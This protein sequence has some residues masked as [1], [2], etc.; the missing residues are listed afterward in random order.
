[1]LCFR[2]G[3]PVSDAADTCD[4]C[5]Q[6]LSSSAAPDTERFAEIQ[7]K[8]RETGRGWKKPA[9]SYDVGEVIAERYEINDVVGAGPLGTV[10]KAFDQEVEVDVA[11]KVI[12]SEYLP[13]E[14]ARN[15][16]LLVLQS[17]RDLVHENVVRCF[18]VDHE[19]DR[20]FYVMQFLKGLTLRKIIDMRRAK[21][22]RFSLDEVEPIF[23]QLCK[24]LDDTSAIM[25]HGGLKPE[26]I[27]ILPDLLKITD[28]G[29]P[30]ALP[31]A[32]YLTAQ[33]GY[34]EASHYL[35]PEVREKQDYDVRAD[36]YSAGVIL[37]ELL[38]G[39]PYRQGDEVSVHACTEEVPEAV[40]QLLGRTVS[41]DPAERPS[42]TAQLRQEL[43]V[44]L[45][46]PSEG[47]IRDAL[48]P[49][50]T[51]DLRRAADPDA[52][53]DAEADAEAEAEAVTR[54]LSTD[55]VATQELPA[56]AA[57]ADA[58]V[59]REVPSPGADG[60]DSVVTTELPS[61]D[62]VVTKEHLAPAPP[63]DE[64][65]QTARRNRADLETAP[66]GEPEE[67]LDFSDPAVPPPEKPGSQVTHQLDIDDVE[68]A[69]QS[70]KSEILADSLEDP[71]EDI[72]TTPPVES[73]ARV[74]PIRMDQ[75]IQE[76]EDELRLS[77]PDGPPPERTQQIDPDM[78]MEG[79]DGEEEEEDREQVLLVPPGDINHS[80]I[81]G[82]TDD[83]MPP[84][85]EE[86]AE[87]S[88]K[89]LAAKLSE[90]VL[91]QDSIDKEV[92]AREALQAFDF[93]A[94]LQQAVEQAHQEVE[95]GSGSV[96]LPRGE[97]E[98]DRPNVVT[99]DVA[100][101]ARG[102]LEVDV[103]AP[104]P[105]ELEEENATLIVAQD[106]EDRAPMTRFVPIL[107]V[108]FVAVLALGTAGAI[109]FITKKRS[110]AALE[111][112]ERKRVA[113][114]ALVNKKEAGAVEAKPD[115]GP[116][117]AALPLSEDASSHKPTQP[118]PTP[119]PE[120]KPKVEPKP[121][122]APKPAPKP[123][124]TPRPR[125]AATPVRPA[126]PTP[127]RVAPVRPSPVKPA[128]AASSKCPR[129]M[130]FISGRPGEDGHCIDLFEFPGRGR[131]P[132]RTGLAGAK[133][134]CRAR[135]LRLCTAREWLRGCG[136]LFPYGRK[137][138][139]NRC[140]TGTGRLVAS[141]GKRRCRSRWGLY[142]MSGNASEWVAD[143]VTMG[144]DA[145]SKEG[146][147]GCMARTR[148]GPLT[149]FRCCSDPSWD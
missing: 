48:G 115:T 4:N 49:P 139:P 126:P 38:T 125:R 64:E 72:L 134:A 97:P 25:P 45:G 23:V 99:P 28:F 85:V 146:H 59:T 141:G 24:A 138:D 87:P 21:G 46:R 9:A 34:K 47:A 93:D 140:N 51:R 66:P 116:A 111:E 78:I 114:M 81:A 22:Q 40:D 13:D 112:L 67:P 32:A 76:T 137:Y 109:Y 19:G 129:G 91:S 143:G 50:I 17:A 147:A 132:K 135:G 1:M 54:Q 58:M 62:A 133:A 127:R 131:V 6:N 39:K 118:E 103:P 105:A 79:E 74:D 101:S 2:C 57:D 53:A 144:G 102:T 123:A 70:G 96:P 61:P 7:K 75:R 113:A 5:G 84:P 106:A 128:P 11:L 142:D 14:E 65:E 41:V 42:T 122:P 145:N 30:E 73:T 71:E 44:A 92:R 80:Q 100:L 110:A 29:L 10:Y 15:H 55:A 104:T 108:A 27:V 77:R 36:V 18:D 83:G 149:G 98:D 26:N 82:E 124:P 148:G 107:I 136:G 94:T 120:P 119:K 8:L 43:L 31:R 33:R 69:S 35:A 89:P 86:A 16:F 56:P 117:V 60:A 88:Y 95:D 130:R 12:S 52:D 68:F 121:E 37:I 20:C 63:S 3:S 90:K